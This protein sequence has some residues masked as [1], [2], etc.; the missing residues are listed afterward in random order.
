MCERLDVWDQ[1]KITGATVHFASQK[2]YGK[3]G[4]CAKVF[5]QISIAFKIHCTK[6]NTQVADLMLTSNFLKQLLKTDF[7]SMLSIT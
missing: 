1:G 5:Q 7:L 3:S 4:Y 6:N 2:Y